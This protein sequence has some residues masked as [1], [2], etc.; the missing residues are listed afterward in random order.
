MKTTE[1]L[2]LLESEGTVET[3]EGMTRYGIPNDKAFGVPMGTM[4]KFA[5][6]IG[7]DH[8]LATELWKTGW[9]EARTVAVFVDEPAK[10]TKRQMD[11]WAKD[12]D[13]W[14]ICDTACFSLFDQT[15][16]AWEK[17]SK[18]I[19]SQREFV[20]RAGYALIWSLSVHDK[21]APNS[22]FA[23]AMCL[24]EGTEPDERPLVKKAADMA[25]RAVGKRN[26]AL[27]KAAIKVA[28]RLAK[29]NDK[30]KK[31]I[32]SHSLRELESENVQQRLKR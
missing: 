18:W 1:V 30:T 32:G 13:S 4:R 19:S 9:Y 31:W 16:H 12:F 28:K 6:Q 27:N 2:A 3:V 14:A 10:V 17:V 7:K 26:V 29:S 20:R 23:A 11:A 15:P 25:L 21:L 24:I 8:S 22:S 5:K